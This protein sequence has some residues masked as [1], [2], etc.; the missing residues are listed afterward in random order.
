MLCQVT[1]GQTAAKIITA[2]QAR[3]RETIA[4]LA[5]RARRLPAGTDDQIAL[6]AGGQ[7]RED[8]LRCRDLTALANRLREALTVVEDVHATVVPDNLE[9][10]LA[11]E[12]TG[13]LY[14]HYWLPRAATATLGDLGSLT[15]WLTAAREDG[16]EFWL[17]TSAQ[18]AQR[19]AEV[20]EQQQ[21]EQAARLSTAVVY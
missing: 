2:I 9:Q 14:R 16:L 10:C 15:F 1:T 13:R 7:T 19:A 17:P 5:E 20:R 4:E 11:Y 3:H 18:L 8:Y 21:A 6:E 12:K